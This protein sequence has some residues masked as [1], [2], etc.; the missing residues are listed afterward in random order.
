MIN[1]H[2]NPNCRVGDMRIRADKGMSAGR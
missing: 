2:L 1:A